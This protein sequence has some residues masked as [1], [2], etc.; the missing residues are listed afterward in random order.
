MRNNNCAWDRKSSIQ[1]LAHSTQE[2]CLLLAV[3][4]LLVTGCIKRNLIIRSE[5]PG[6]DLLVNDKALGT[7]PHSYDFEWYGWHR[8]TLT[9]AGYER[10]EERVLINAPLYLWIPLDLLMEL[11]PVPIHDHK[12]LTYQLRPKQPLP[13][14]TPPSLGEPAPTNPAPPPREEGDG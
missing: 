1:Q 9:K 7:T 3:C 2:L 12:T 8:V 13:A 6:A 10:L 14:P 5:P 11:L 4:C